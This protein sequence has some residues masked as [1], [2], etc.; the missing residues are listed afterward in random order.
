MTKPSLWYAQSDNQKK[1][2]K[3]DLNHK[4]FL[5]SSAGKKKQNLKHALLSFIAFL[6][7]MAFYSFDLICHTQNDSKWSILNFGAYRISKCSNKWK[8]NKQKERIP[9]WKTRKQF[10]R[11]LPTLRNTKM[12]VW[13][14]SQPGK[15]YQARWKGTLQDT[16]LMAVRFKDC[17]LR[18]YFPICI[19]IWNM[20][21]PFQTR[22][23]NYKF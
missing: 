17:R 9:V 6:L 13:Q 20:L 19:F 4:A 21:H 12:T 7:G 23:S 22:E 10:Y 16:T 15:Q 1:A 5:Q 18:A 3:R 14:V 2:R 11:V 8:Q